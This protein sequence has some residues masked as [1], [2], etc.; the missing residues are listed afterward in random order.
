MP[1]LKDLTK[2][3]NISL[4]GEL[5]DLNLSLNTSIDQLNTIVASAVRASGL[6]NDAAVNISN[7]THNLSSRVQEQASALEETT[8]TISE[9]NIT[10]Q[11]NSENATQASFVARK[12]QDQ[13][14]QGSKVM[15]ETLEA[16]TKIQESSHR[17]SD[18]VTLIDSIAF[19]TNLL[20]LNAAVEAARAGEQGRGFA[21]VAGEVRTLAQ[22]SA[23]AARDITQ[24]ITESVER[25]DYGTKLA[26]E[27]G[28]VL[29]EITSSISQVTSTVETIAQASSE[30]ANS[31]SQV[32]ISINSIDRVTQENSALVESTVAALDSMTE[33]SARLSQDMSIFRTAGQNSLPKP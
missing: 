15:Q 27:S 28:K 20:A 32:N 4:E 33:E 3:V 23:E 16:M 10:V 6:V 7:D 18:I 8:T 2:R 21:V 31:I 22:E 14:L 1:W 17:I 9:M 5:G 26:A 13:T 12:V 25:I 30:Q 29:D 11:N 24:L 19:Q